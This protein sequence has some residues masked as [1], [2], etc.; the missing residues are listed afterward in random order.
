MK[1]RTDISLTPQQLFDAV[2][3]SPLHW[4]WKT[5]RLER[6]SLLDYTQRPASA[7]VAIAELYHE[8]SKLF[9]QILPELAMS[10]V[11]AGE[12]R[13]EFVQRRAAAI[14]SG[15]STGDVIGGPWREL[16]TELGRAADPDLF[17]AVEL[18]ILAGELL[19]T[20]EPVSDTL[21]VIKHLSIAELNVLSHV[22][23]LTSAASEVARSGPSLFTLG[24][25]SRNEILFGARG[26]RRTL[27]EAGQ[28]AQ[29]ILRQAAQLSLE[30]SLQYEFLDR[31]VDEV[32]ESDGITEGTLLILE[33]GGDVDAG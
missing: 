27:L 3:Y 19:A 14:R 9:P 6:N 12:V 22:T 2:L 32:M 1:R 11:Q 23:Q 21:L 10:R 20:Y 13:R 31:A 28:V 17:Y 30:V 26:Y 8:N 25:F 4:P 5:T 15:G 29:E 7:N 16:L 24:C 18:R 33:S